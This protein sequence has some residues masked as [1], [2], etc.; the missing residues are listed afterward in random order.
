M[1]IIRLLLGHLLDTFWAPSEHLL[2][3]PVQ[4]LRSLITMAT[5]DQDRLQQY[6]E[7][8]GIIS[9]HQGGAPPSAYPDRELRWLISSCWN[10]GAHHVRYW[11]Y[12]IIPFTP[13]KCHH[14]D[15]PGNTWP[16]ACSGRSQRNQL[17]LPVKSRRVIPT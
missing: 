14:V 15:D 8:A 10:R 12:A 3:P 1:A 11:R 6:K 13:N 5:H 7:A 4:V 9:T 16:R 17:A 2:T